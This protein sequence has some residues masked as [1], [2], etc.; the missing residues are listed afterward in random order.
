MLRDQIKAFEDELKRLRKEG[1]SLSTQQN[2]CDS[3][4]EKLKG[5]RTLYERDDQWW[6]KWKSMPKSLMGPYQDSKEEP[7]QV[8]RL[9]KISVVDEPEKAEHEKIYNL[10]K[11]YREAL[12]ETAIM[13]PAKKYIGEDSFIILK[14]ISK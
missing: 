8:Y 9:L 6:T 13:I 2:N 4:I 12:P 3:K 7:R 14:Y 5:D 11:R 10:M 1:I